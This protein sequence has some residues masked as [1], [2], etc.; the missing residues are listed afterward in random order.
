MCKTSISCGSTR[1]S[2]SVEC[3][4]KDVCCAAAGLT[5]SIFPFGCSGWLPDISKLSLPGLRCAKPAFLVAPHADQAP[6][7]A[8]GKMFVAQRPV[9]KFRLSIWM[10]V[11]LMKPALI[12]KAIK[13][14]ETVLKNLPAS[15]Q[16][17]RRPGTMS[18]A[19]YIVESVLRLKVMGLGDSE[20]SVLVDAVEELL[21]HASS[22][23][24]TTSLQRAISQT[25]G[26]RQLQ[27]RAETRAVAEAALRP[28][29]STSMEVPEKLMELFEEVAKEATKGMV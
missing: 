14:F 4:R 28:V 21:L 13:C 10:L 18:R 5:I 3:Y 6:L 25:R 12:L 7:S 29:S 26:V 11:E 16:V 8:T 23:A 27:P 19:A 17:A 1:G 20:Y 24:E 9:S 2:S 15:D 22:V